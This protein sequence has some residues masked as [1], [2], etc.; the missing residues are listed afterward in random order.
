MSTERIAGNDWRNARLLFDDVAVAV[1]DNNIILDTPDADGFF[2][3]HFTDLE[4]NRLPDELVEGRCIPDGLRPLIVFTRRH[5]GGNVITRYIGKVI[6]FNGDDPGTENDATTV[7]IRGRFTRATTN[8][9]GSIAIAGGDYETE[10][11]T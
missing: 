5:P 8:G 3:G 7:M 9:N 2:E 1:N 10:K 11:P 6:T 4:G